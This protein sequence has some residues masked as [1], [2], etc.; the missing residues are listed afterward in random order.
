MVAAEEERLKKTMEALEQS[1]VEQIA[2][3]H[4]TG[5]EGMSMLQKY[6][7]NNFIKNNTGNVFML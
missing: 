4:C 1:G 5:D 3:S 2:V 6:F 7:G